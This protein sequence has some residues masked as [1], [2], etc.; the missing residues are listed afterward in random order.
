M[1]IHYNKTFNSYEVAECDCKFGKD[2]TLDGRPLII[3]DDLNSIKH[4]ADKYGYILVKRNYNKLKPCMCGCTKRRRVQ[5]DDLYYIECKSCERYATGKTV[6]EAVNK[7]NTMM[8]PKPKPKKI[9]SDECKK[10][11]SESAKA[12][13]ARK[14]EEE[15]GSTK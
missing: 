9:I 5:K 15:N 2:I 11:L 12:Y 13:W 6:I 4:E 7:W 10:K 8:T 3:A 1:K 14:K